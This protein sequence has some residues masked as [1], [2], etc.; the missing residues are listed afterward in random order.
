MSKGILTINAGS[1]SIKFALYK[2]DG[3]LAGK[4][5][6][7]GQ[8]D[9]IG[10]NAT[11]MV[12]KDRAGEKIADATPALAVYLRQGDPEPQALQDL[13]TMRVAVPDRPARRPSPL[14]SSRPARAS[15]G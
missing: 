8:I 6:L 3:G 2:L 13:T 10:T 11:K 14:R 1:S 12:A 9:G 15:G 4:P 5:T 7:S